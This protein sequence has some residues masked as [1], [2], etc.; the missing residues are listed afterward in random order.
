ALLPRA[1]STFCQSMSCAPAP[2]ANAIRADVAKTS[3]VRM[4]YLRSVSFTIRAVSICQSHG[5]L[6]ALARSDDRSPV[7]GL[8]SAHA[9]FRVPGTTRNTPG[10]TNHEKSDNDHLGACCGELDDDSERG[11]HR[12]GGAAGREGRRH[13]REVL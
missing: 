10:R 6:A 4:T 9:R 8:H 3:V 2:L 7:L 12:D 11:R 5:R 1:A 13:A